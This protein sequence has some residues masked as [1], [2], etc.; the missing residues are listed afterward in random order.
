MILRTFLRTHRPIRAIRNSSENLRAIPS[1]RGSH[2]PPIERVLGALPATNYD[3]IVIPG[4]ASDLE[5]V[6]VARRLGL[7]QR[8]HPLLSLLAILAAPVLL[9][10]LITGWLIR[11]GRRMRR[12]ATTA[13]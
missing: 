4:L 3:A 7:L 5:R 8:T 6:S 1:D 13:T 10:G 2:L 9:L 11:R 12:R